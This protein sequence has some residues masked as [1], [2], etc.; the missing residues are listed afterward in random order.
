MLPAT[1]YYSPP[2][3][4]KDSPNYNY[5]YY[6]IASVVGSPQKYALV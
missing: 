5:D 4:V 3:N 1:Y 6:N 2:P